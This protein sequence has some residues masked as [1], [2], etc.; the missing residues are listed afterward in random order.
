MCQQMNHNRIHKV[1]GIRHSQEIRK[2]ILSHS[3][4]VQFELYVAK[5]WEPYLELSCRHAGSC[6][7]RF[8]IPEVKSLSLNRYPLL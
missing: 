7:R 6:S 8:L 2:D 4:M 3:H 5:L 1:R